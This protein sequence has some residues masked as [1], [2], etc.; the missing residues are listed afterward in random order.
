MVLATGDQFSLS[1]FA[2]TKGGAKGQAQV[3]FVY[4]DGSK[5]KI[6]LKLK[7]ASGGYQLFTGSESLSGSDVVKVKVTL[8]GTNTSGKLLIDDV[9]LDHAALLRTLP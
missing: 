9:R 2:R 8:K 4:A 6:T 7:N 3:V 5:T 1:L